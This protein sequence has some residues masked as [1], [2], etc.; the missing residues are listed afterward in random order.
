[1]GVGVTWLIAPSM[2][3]GQVS[4]P[5]CP[6]HVCGQGEHAQLSLAYGMG[7]GKVRVANCSEHGCGQGVSPAW[8][9]VG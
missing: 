2:R 7:G 9:W 6:Q 3:V 4:M 8:A 1:M 5:D